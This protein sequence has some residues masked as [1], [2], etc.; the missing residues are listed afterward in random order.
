MA[1]ASAVHRGLEIIMKYEPDATTAA[2][3]DV[4]FCGTY[5]PDKMTKE[6]LEELEGL[7]WH[8]QDDSWAKF[9]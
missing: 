5:E 8:E 2:E 3:H 7:G 1:S 6:D 4:I 9:T